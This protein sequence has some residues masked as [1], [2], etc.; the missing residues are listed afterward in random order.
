MTKTDVTI[1][2]TGLIALIFGIIN[3]YN[4][5]MAPMVKGVYDSKG[6]YYGTTATITDMAPFIMGKGY[7][8]VLY[9]KDGN[10]L[11]NDCIRIYPQ[12]KRIT[13]LPVIGKIIKKYQ[14]YKNR[15]SKAE[16]ELFEAL[17]NKLMRDIDVTIKARKI[18]KYN[19][20]LSK[21]KIYQ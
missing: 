8:L 6:K 10:Y 15:P 18:D 7:A 14:E 20:A 3:S 1:L 17:A 16:K 19:K 2:T 21:Y 5:L 12:P 4:Y 13:T 11:G 9:D